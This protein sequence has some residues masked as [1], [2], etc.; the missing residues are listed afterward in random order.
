[1]IENTVRGLMVCRVNFCLTCNEFYYK[2]KN[3][4]TLLKN[5]HLSEKYNNQKLI[6]NSS[7]CK[8]KKIIKIIN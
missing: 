6:S 5:I 1:M 7:Y 4:T 2:I 3:D 8:Q